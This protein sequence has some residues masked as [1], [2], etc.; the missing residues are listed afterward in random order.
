MNRGTRGVANQHISL[1][2]AQD[3]PAGATAGGR[4][5]PEPRFPQRCPLSHDL[6]GAG[7]EEVFKASLGEHVVLGQRDRAY[8]PGPVAEGGGFNAE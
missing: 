8:S 3:R 6:R 5:A 4:A 1:E 7:V 2:T